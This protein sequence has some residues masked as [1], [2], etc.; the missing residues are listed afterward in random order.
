MKKGVALALAVCLTLSSSPV[1][2]AQTAP[3]TRETPPGG[4]PWPRMTTV[5]GA[6][7]SIYQPQLNSWNGNLLDAYAAVKIKVSGSE[8]TNY[9]V[10]W[11]TARTEV[12]KV[13]RVV[14]LN[15]FALTKQNFP[16]LA[17]N[18]SAYAAAFKGAM[19]W[20]DSL[21]L[22][23]LETALATTSVDSQQQR[24]AVNNDP[25]RII[26]STTPAVLVSIDGKP[27]LRPS[28]DGFRKVL[29]TRALILADASTNTYYLALMDGWVQSQSVNGPWTLAK[30]PPASI[31]TIRSAA[32]AD[33]QNQVLGNPK[34]SL[35]NAYED[36]EAPRVHVVTTQT[37]LLLSQGAPQFAP[38]RGTT[39]S[40]VVNSADDIF[41][42]GD[43]ESYYV[44]IGGR[45][46]IAPSL[47]EGPWTYEPAT[48]LP[49]TF[50]MI[51]DYS[52][53]ADVLV[54]VPGTPQAK[55]ALI[56]NQ[57]PQTATISRTAA[58]T[59][60]KYDGAPNFK[61]VQG[62][63][64]TYAVNS[65]TP[66][67]YE[68]GGSY[69]ACQTAV[70]FKSSA[71]TG[72]WTVATSVPVSIYTIPA[73]AP[74]HY[75]T[76]VK[77]YGYTPTSVYVGYTPGYYGTLLST[78]GVVVYGT[79]YSYPPYIG[80]TLWVPTPY[81][82][83]VGAAFSWNAAAGWALGFGL[84][85]AAGALSPWWGPVGYW[86]WGGAAPAWGWAGYGG[87][88]STNFYG[89]WGN[90]A[91]AGTRAA[92][93]NPATGNIG[94]GARGRA[95]NPVTG[96]SGVAA[97]GGDFN[98]NTGNFAAG[99]AGA[100]YNPRTGVVK[101]GAQGVYGN[102]YTGHASSVD[103]GFAY[104]PSTGNGIA[105]NGNN[106][107][108]DHNG[109]VYRSNVSSGWQQHV[110]SG[111]QGLSSSNLR[112]SLN[113]QSFSRALG[114]QRWGGFRSGGWAGRFGGG[115]FADRGFG[116]GFGGRFGGGGFG[117][118]RGGRR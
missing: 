55:E 10:I 60:V 85:F 80:S 46:F 24:V 90:A 61:P 35:E 104:R 117:G 102:A 52:P 34:Q 57:I 28:A 56:A 22:D 27:V 91:F 81:T 40:Y 17:S 41:K 43:S 16:T 14:T 26:F 68:P 93:A 83:G 116:G 31:E 103:R 79:G 75:V 71:P 47:E 74:L 65:R 67:I 19:P 58:H 100:S 109:N 110:G 118:F 70:W 115:G 87:V 112:S 73:S 20:T 64:L 76:Y 99:R 89:H 84:G 32:I 4:D 37:E 49:A 77:I 50:A 86:G 106:L 21:P 114:S 30:D 101:G 18:G 13:N 23:E 88:A 1:A 48:K 92:W 63:S 82:Y 78:D 5:N 3:A 2:F 113:D 95:Y 62:T 107:Y 15:D 7:I 96:T 8:E 94:A 72:P 51:P 44:L 36:G 69:Y 12:D 108:A 97:R 25:P 11:F 45:W 66:I 33:D 42:D 105:Y 39:L 98:A 53:K 38:L 54:A 111:W 6:T 59:T 29:N 9:G